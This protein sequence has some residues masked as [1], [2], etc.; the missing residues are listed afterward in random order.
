MTLF[1]QIVL[2]QLTRNAFKR[3]T[4]TTVTAQLNDFE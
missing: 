2:I 3:A 4:Q 1:T